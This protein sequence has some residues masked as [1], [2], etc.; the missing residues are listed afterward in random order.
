[1]LDVIKCIRFWLTYP[2]HLPHPASR[3]FLDTY[4][5]AEVRYRVLLKYRDRPC[6]ACGRGPKQGVWLHVDHIKPRKT[7]PHLALDINNLQILCGCCNK[8]KA[9]WDSTDWR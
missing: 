3:E 6:M 9:S 2:R 8:G 4:E 1:M 5:W 7:H